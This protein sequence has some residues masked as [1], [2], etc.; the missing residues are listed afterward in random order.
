MAEYVGHVSLTLWPEPCR[1]A[2]MKQRHVVIVAFPGLQPLDAVGPFEVFSGATLAAE[3]ARPIGRLP[4]HP[5]LEASRAG[6]GRRAGWAWCS[7]PLPG[8]DEHIDTL[9]IAGGDGAQSARRRRRR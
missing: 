8:G 7:E 1:L 4:G 9:V 5:R 2:G 6:P 3:V